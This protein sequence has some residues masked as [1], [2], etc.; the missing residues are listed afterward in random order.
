[1]EPLS[2]GELNGPATLCWATAHMQQAFAVKK[3]FLAL[4]IRERGEI[5]NPTQ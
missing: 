4:Q 2:V 1:V 3:T 5:R